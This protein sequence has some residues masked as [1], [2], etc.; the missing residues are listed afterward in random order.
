MIKTKFKNVFGKNKGLTG[1]KEI[2]KL[3]QGDS[4]NFNDLPVPNCSLNVSVNFKY[5]LIPVL[6]LNAVFHFTNTY[7]LTDS[8][9]NFTEINTEHAFITYYFSN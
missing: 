4:V 3:L 6:M 2:L 8:R 1:L 5:A 9:N 7:I